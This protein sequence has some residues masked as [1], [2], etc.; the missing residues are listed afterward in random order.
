M[1]L[2]RGGSRRSVADHYKVSPDALWRHWTSHVSDDAKASMKAAYLKP[3][4]TIEEILREES[5]GL[6]ERLAAYR[7][8]CWRLFNDA[9]E[10]ADAKGVAPL[11]RELIRVEELIAQQTG[12]LRAKA[13]TPVA[14]LHMTAD[15][16]RLRQTIALALR[17]YP[18]ALAAVSA[19]L[20]EMDQVAPVAL[21]GPGATH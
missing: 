17:P 3:S 11:V 13:S 1:A 12:E 20:R 10:N 19:A 5:P 7:A 16:A 4:A 15:F 2:A 21:A 18:V 8:G 6:L 9:V 14:H